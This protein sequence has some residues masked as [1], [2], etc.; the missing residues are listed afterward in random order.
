MLDLVKLVQI[1]LNGYRQPQAVLRFKF[2]EEK[3]WLKNQDVWKGFWGIRI[4]LGCDSFFLEP[5]RLE[6][7]QLEAQCFTKALKTF[8]KEYQV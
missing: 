6:E 3:G 2:S 7:I 8:I 5:I 4:G 1:Q